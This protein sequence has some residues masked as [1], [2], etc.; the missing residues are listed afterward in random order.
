MLYK[1]DFLGVFIGV[2][3]VL[4]HKN[5]IEKQKLKL[6]IQLTPAPIMQKATPGWPFALLV[7]LVRTRSN[8]RGSAGACIASGDNARRAV[9]P[10]GGLL[11]YWW[12]W[13]GR[14][15]TC[16]VQPVLA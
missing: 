3:Q 10:P 15:A 4:N 6:A 1:P 14:E 9:N 12:R 7:A 11:H 5:S 2:S 16:E 8:V 13:C